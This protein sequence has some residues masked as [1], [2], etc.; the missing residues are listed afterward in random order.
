MYVLQGHKYLYIYYN[1]SGRSLRLFLENLR[2]LKSEAGQIETDFNVQKS[3]CRSC[4]VFSKLTLSF[5]SY[6]SI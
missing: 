1:S 5:Q 3:K 6:F 4:K 2:N